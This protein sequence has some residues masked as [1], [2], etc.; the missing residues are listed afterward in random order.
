MR[1]LIIGSWN[2]ANCC[3]ELANFV[4][5]RIPKL[6]MSN[7]IRRYSNALLPDRAAIKVCEKN[8]RARPL[9][10]ASLLKLIKKNV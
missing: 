1:I 5:Y 8:V 9:N 10:L 6:L 2:R 7:A 4:T 3:Q